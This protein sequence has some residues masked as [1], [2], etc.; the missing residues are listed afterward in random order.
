MI[1]DEKSD[2]YTDEKPYGPWSMALK[3]MIERDNRLEK[4]ER[5]KMVEARDRELMANQPYP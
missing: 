5:R 3:S 2:F 4:E 1:N